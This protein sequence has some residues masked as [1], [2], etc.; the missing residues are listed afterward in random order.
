MQKINFQNLPSTTTPVNATDLNQLQTNVENAINS[1]IDS[2]SNS[3]GYY[4]KYEDGTLIQWGIRELGSVAITGQGVGVYISG[5]Q[6]AI[7]YPISF[8]SRP[9]YRNISVQKASSSTASS[10]AVYQPERSC[11]CCR[12]SGKNTA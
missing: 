3:N 8:I 12:S 5:D 10:D 1:V 9:I 11:S 2:G 7:T 4:T 6:T